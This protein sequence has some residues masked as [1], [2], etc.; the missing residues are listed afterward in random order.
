MALSDKID[1]TVEPH[2]DASTD[3]NSGRGKIKTISTK[4]MCRI[5]KVVA[6]SLN[7]FLVVQNQSTIERAGHG[8]T[9][10]GLNAAYGAANYAWFCDYIITVWQPLK[11]VQ[12]ETALTAS[13]WQYSK[14]R[15]VGTNDA[16]REYTRHSIYFDIPSGDFRPLTEIEEDEFNTFVEKAN[17]LRKADTDNK[18]T[19]YTNS[20]NARDNFQRILSLVD[21]DDDNG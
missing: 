18:T 3:I 5:M 1:T 16:T 6:E 21:K 12:S 20:P 14:I 15:E 19:Q 13:G 8:D 7:C 2:F 10:M 4:E 11:R 9:P 17:A